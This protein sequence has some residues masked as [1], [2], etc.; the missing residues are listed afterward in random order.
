LTYGE[1]DHRAR[2]LA[3]TLQSRGL[4]GERALLLCPP[5]LDYVTAFFGCLYAGVVA[6]PI[7]PPRR[8]RGMDRLHPV[9]ADA[10]AAA[11]IAP[12]AVAAGTRRIDQR[13]QLSGLHWVILNEEGAEASSWHEPDLGGDD[14]AVL[15]YTSGSTATPRG[16]MLTHGNLLH[17]SQAI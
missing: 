8:A 17:N 4:A 1:L 11:V 7:Y 6:V 12:H 13:L 10:Q 2:V 15:Q 9:V 14:L 16:V 5:G 3:A